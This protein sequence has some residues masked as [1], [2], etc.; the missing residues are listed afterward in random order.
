MCSRCWVR[1]RA[2]ELRQKCADDPVWQGLDTDMGVTRMSMTPEDLD[3]MINV[4]TPPAREIARR[5][6][7]VVGRDSLEL[8]KA[9]PALGDVSHEILNNAW[10]CMHVLQTPQDSGPLL[11]LPVSKGSLKHVSLCQRVGFCMCGAA[12]SQRRKFR[13][14]LGSLLGRFFKKGSQ[15]RALH[16]RAEAILRVSRARMDLDVAVST[17][18]VGFG[19]LNSN[20]F[21]VKPLRYAGASDISCFEPAGDAVD[22]EAVGA[23]LD[24]ED[25][26]VADIMTLD[27]A[28]RTRSKTNVCNKT[29][30]YTAHT[31]TTKNKRHS[32]VADFKPLAYVAPVVPGIR[33]HVWPPEI[34]V[35]NAAAAAGRGGR[36]RRG[37]GRGRGR[38][39]RAAAIAQPEQ[40]LP[41]DVPE[42][43]ADVEA[44]DAVMSEA[45]EELAAAAGWQLSSSDSDEEQLQ[46]RGPPR[47]GISTRALSSVVH[48]RRPE[49]GASLRVQ[50]P[51]P[52][53]PPPAGSAAR[54]PRIMLKD[55]RSD[56]P[57]ILF[58]EN[59]RGQKS[60]VRLSTTFGK[61]WSDAKAVCAQHHGRNCGRSRGMR[62]A[63][64]L[65]YLWA[66]LQMADDPSMTSKEVHEAYQPDF[67]TR[68]AARL[69]FESLGD[70]VREF[71]LA[72][73]GGPGLGEPLESG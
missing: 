66:W 52:P 20:D 45:D 5:T 8:D 18:F 12:F 21:T 46:R 13:E 60:Y 54:R 39:G 33:A 30:A 49:T 44:A 25:F 9:A 36:G 65:G 64:P 53:P 3:M 15:A 69:E 31:H 72:E 16:D 32:L 34:R 38:R 73:C 67:E 43:L 17:W 4:I 19:N 10:S 59:K 37:R 70:A 68:C 22:F 28:R 24:L 41:P 62:E 61:S 26:Y 55:F 7:E 6:L 47:A 29:S 51:P 63:R 40:L 42:P 71:L 2:E 14:A 35:P 11:P 50:V 58:S 1:R 56:W 57:K 48:G 23:S 27:T